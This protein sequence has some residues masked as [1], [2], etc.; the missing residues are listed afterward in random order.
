MKCLLVA[1]RFVHKVG[2]YYNFPLGIAY[3]SAVLKRAGHEVH[4]LN[5]NNVEGA[6]DDLVTEAVRRIAPDMMGTGGLSPHFVPVRDI[7]AAGR[8][9]RPEM[10]TVVGSG[11]FSSDP[12]TVAGM[13]DIDAGVV[14]EG[15]ETIVELAAALDD[16]RPLDQVAGLL[17]RDAAGSFRRTAERPVIRDLDSLPW[18]DWEGFGME[19]YLASQNVA[20]DYFLHGRDDA[21]SMPMISS[22][23]C[24]YG[25]TFC[26]HPLGRIYRQRSLDNVF[27]E[28]DAAIARYG[29]NMVAILDELFAV[30]KDRLAEFCE[31]IK[32]YGLDWMVQLHV[33]AVDAPTVRLMKDAG[34]TYVSLGIESMSGSVLRSMAKKATPVAI[35]DALRVTRA[36]GIGIQ[37]NF[38]FG[39]PAETPDTVNETFDWWANNRGYQVSLSLMVPY[40]GTPLYHQGLKSGRIADR[41]AHFLDP[42]VNLTDMDD[43]TMRRLRLQILVARET[44]LRPAR[45]LAFEREDGS[46]PRGELYRI[47]WRCPD[48]GHDSDYRR[49]AM[50]N[51]HQFQSFGL[52]CRGCA[53]RFDVPNLA[54]RRWILPD[55]QER[56]EATKARFE[57]ALARRDTVELRRAVSEYQEIGQQTWRSMD[58]PEAWIQVHFELGRFAMEHARTPEWAVAHFSQAML[59]RAFDPACHFAYAEALL[60][61]GAPH[62]AALHF[63]QAARLLLSSGQTASLQVVRLQRLVKD[64]RATKPPVYFRAA[65]KPNTMSC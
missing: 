57:Q 56:F 17:Y 38:I 16:G 21:R 59:R 24:P 14:G 63:E 18:P 35:D 53:G 61:D 58:R 20:D 42:N 51:Q 8:A 13:L 9:A 46:S 27:A 22:R 29:I 1:P 5:L 19:G 7:L 64:L 55:L 54:R 52:T 33:N 15:E 39:D 11:V 44:L 32:P 43:E 49:V 41:R 26:F 45:V 28:L 23:S 6:A 60:A 4:C 10:V 31:R 40:P 37:G 25:C 65:D 2:A 12:E 62:A 48:C 34:C 50:D 3:I 36:S 30:K 47:L